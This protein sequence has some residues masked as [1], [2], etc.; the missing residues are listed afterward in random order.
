MKKT[1]KIRDRVFLV[2]VLALTVHTGVMAQVYAKTN[3]T[4]TY[5]EVVDF[6]KKLDKKYKQATLKEVGKT[7]IGQPLQLFSI[8]GSEDPAK[9]KKARLLINNGIHPGEPDGINASMHLADEILGNWKKYAPLF[10]SV[11]LYIIA[12]YNIDG[13]LRRG[14]SSRANQDGPAEYGFRGNYQN[15]DLNRDFMKMDTKNAVSFARIFHE[16]DPHLIIDTHVSNGADYQ[17]TFTYFFTEPSKWPKGLADLSRQMEKEFSAGMQ[18]QKIDV[19]P[20]V[21][22][23]SETPL[24]GI[25]AFDDSP[26]YCTGYASLFNCIGVTTE[27][28]MLK[29]FDERVRTTYASLQTLLHLCAR[30]RDDLRQHQQDDPAPDGRLAVTYQ[31]DTTKAE[32]I[33]FKGYEHAYR[34]SEVT[35]QQQLYYD[36]TKPFT[37]EINYYTTYVPKTTVQLPKAYIVPQSYDNAVD[38]LKANKVNMKKIKHDTLVQVEYYVAKKASAGSNPYEGHYYHQ[39]VEVEKMTLTKKFF[40]GDYLVDCSGRQKRFVAEALEPLATDSYFRWNLF[41]A[42]LQQKE[43]FSDYVFDQKAAEILAKDPVLKKKFEEKKAA[44]PAFSKDS[45]EQLLFIYRNSSWY[46]GTAWEIPVYR[47]F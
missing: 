42:C 46:E 13:C 28:H 6:Y 43:W 45:F 17:Y 9:S 31:L 19:V 22:H 40:K 15:L 47:I 18:Q 44:E 37:H 7:D 20:Y 1:D 39:Q 38:R 5:E 34:K 25:V 3:Y 2:L 41:D 12:V 23:H 29:P 11:E 21:N 35:G 16:V 30:H 33:M 32:K 36:R 27:T 26:R 14:T 4:P 24:G 10:D 8:G